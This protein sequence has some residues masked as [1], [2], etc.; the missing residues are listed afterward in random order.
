MDTQYSTVVDIT[1]FFK[2]KLKYVYFLIFFFYLVHFYSV[3][4]MTSNNYY[5]HLLHMHI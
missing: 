5:S 2:Y 3:L 1:L 4:V